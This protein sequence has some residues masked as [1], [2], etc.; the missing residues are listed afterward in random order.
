MSAFRTVA[1]VIV[2]VFAVRIEVALAAE[3]DRLILPRPP[4]PFEGKLEPREQDSTMQRLSPIKAPD[5]APHI[6]LGLAPQARLAGRCLR[7]IWTD[8]RRAA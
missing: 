6:T 7:P 1:I 3:Q 5:G 8:L 2:F 4:A